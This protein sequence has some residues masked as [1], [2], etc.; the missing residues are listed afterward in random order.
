MIILSHRPA[1]AYYRTSFTRTG[2]S[3]L[4]V[5]VQDLQHDLPVAGVPPPDLLLHPVWPHDSLRQADPG[6]YGQRDKISA[7]K[8]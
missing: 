6:H 4:S 3:P 2:R 7:F 8:W 1:V 5:L